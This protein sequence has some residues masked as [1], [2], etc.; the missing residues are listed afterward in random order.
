MKLAVY[1]SEAH[2]IHIFE[3]KNKDNYFEFEFI[4]EILTEETVD[5]CKGFDGILINTLCLV[6]ENI[7]KKL[8]EN[9]VKFVAS[10][11]AGINHL[12]LEA[13]SKHGLLA[14]NV[15]SYSPNAISELTIM[16]VLNLLRHMKPVQRGVDNYDFNTD[17]VCGKELKSLNV[18]LIGS[19]NIGLETIRILQGFNCKTRVLDTLLSKEGQNIKEI[20]SPDI[21]NVEQFGASHSG[22]DTLLA[23]SDILICH[24]PLFDS[25]H[26]II[27]KNF[28]NRCKDGVILINAA[29]G[30]IFNA[31]DVLD[32]LENKKV[33]AFAFDVY[34]G[35]ER[36]V[37]KK[38]NA[39]EFNDGVIEKLCARDDVIFTP[40][41]GYY[42]EEALRAMIEI[43][44]DN[45]QS[46]N[47]TGDC[48]NKVNK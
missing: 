21:Q 14:C 18:G 26:H 37:C 2:N 22:L 43:S 24:M 46:F 33:S 9:G 45:L 7:C 29:R 12:N 19:G 44:L 25:T 27:D 4:E 15:P 11:A 32:A 42:T 31:A 30:G 48:K 28:I 40:H 36:F 41:I 3:N 38:S 20:P 47:N 35:E 13:L 8:K 39:E 34:E 6:D 16:L 17:L 23:T 1:C 5:K 10:R